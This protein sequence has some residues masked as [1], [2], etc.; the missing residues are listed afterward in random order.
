LSLLEQAAP[1]LQG[2]DPRRVRLLRQAAAQLDIVQGERL[3]LTM[4]LIDLRD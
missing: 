3:M 2:A 1:L 4:P